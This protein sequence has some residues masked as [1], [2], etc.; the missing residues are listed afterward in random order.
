MEASNLLT[1][2]EV[3]KILR[4]SPGTIYGWRHR[5]Y[6]PRAVE[7]SPGTPRYEKTEVFRW[8]KARTGQ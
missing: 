5:K 6:G 4:V 7:L 1:I 2:K 8:L 3:A